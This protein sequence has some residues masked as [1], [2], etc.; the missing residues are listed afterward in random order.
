MG[1][2]EKAE[3]MLEKI[4][5]SY[6]EGF[7]NAL[8]GSDDSRTSTNSFTTGDAIGHTIAAVITGGASLVATVPS[9]IGQ[10]ED[11]ETKSALDA[12]F[13]K[14]KSDGKDILKGKW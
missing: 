10:G 13:E 9:L 14:G 1:K 3:K 8:S 7:V 12:A 4:N 2:T 11:K 6:K 5:D